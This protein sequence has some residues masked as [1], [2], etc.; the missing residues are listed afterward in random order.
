[1]WALS[2]FVAATLG[3]PFAAVT[4]GVFA[5][6][7]GIIIELAGRAVARTQVAKF[8]AFLYRVIFGECFTHGS[9]P[10]S[11]EERPPVPADDSPHNDESRWSAD[12]LVGLK[13]VSPADWSGFAYMLPACP[14]SFELVQTFL[15]CDA[16]GQRLLPQM[17]HTTILNVV[18]GQPLTVL[19]LAQ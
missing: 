14:G 9:A 5:V 17:G 10:P 4:I 16:L 13:L 8:D 15:W 1:M 7:V 2:A 18:S 19:A 12:G 11:V 3:T 6:L